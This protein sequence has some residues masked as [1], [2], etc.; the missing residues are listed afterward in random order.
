MIIALAGR[1]IDAPGATPPRFPLENAG[2]VKRRLR[3]LFVK[4]SA[5]A[6]VSSAACGADLIAQQEATILGMRRRIVLPFNRERFR[7]SSVT[8]RPGN[9]GGIYDLLLDEVDRLGDL[10]TLA[11]NGDDFN[12]YA[13]AT[14]RILQEAAALDNGEQSVK[15]VVVWDGQSRGSDDLTQAF[16]D[17]AK[18]RGM[19]V[20]QVNTL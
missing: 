3:E 6:L 14:R 10:V 12:A 2:E 20:L 7:N 18:K 5:T 4:E 17:E 15:A 11:G 9:W 13:E 8:D 16:A 1:R 19:E